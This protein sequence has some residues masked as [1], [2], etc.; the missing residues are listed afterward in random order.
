MGEM[1]RVAAHEVHVDG[2]ILEQAVV[3]LL[4]G[5]VVNYYVFTDELP[6]TEW[7]GGTIEIVGEFAYWNG[8]RLE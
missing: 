5:K 3:E 6:M 2:R 4:S 1:R 8:K 7:L